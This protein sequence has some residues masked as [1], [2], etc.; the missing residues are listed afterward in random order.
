MVC[1]L[2]TKE[3]A[4]IDTNNAKYAVIYKGEFLPDEGDVCTLDGI[5]MPEKD[6][7]AVMKDW[8]EENRPLLGDDV[9]IYNYQLAVK[10]PGTTMEG[11]V[12]Y[13]QENDG[14]KIPCD[15]SVA[16]QNTV[17]NLIHFDS[18]SEAAGAFAT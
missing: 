14:G 1:D 11:V 4:I 12:Q 10:K 5:C 9:H 7:E 3:E 18:D 13:C 6:A 2:N 17:F 16:T 15:E 8:D